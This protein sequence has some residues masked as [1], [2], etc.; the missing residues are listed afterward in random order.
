MRLFLQ[1][2][3][4]LKVWCRHSKYNS[5][6]QE[7]ECD[8]FGGLPL[9]YINRW[10]NLGATPSCS[11]RYVIRVI[12]YGMVQHRR[13]NFYDIISL[14]SDKKSI[15]WVDKV[16]WRIPYTIS[17]NDLLEVRQL[18]TLLFCFSWRKPGYFGECGSYF[19]AVTFELHVIFI[20]ALGKSI[21]VSD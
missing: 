11:Q 19:R 20:N 9:Q 18:A 21:H 10:R 15:L 14:Y 13:P 6:C 8:Y 7:F 5:G 1:R 12:G 4:I 3:R 17:W 2:S 16:S